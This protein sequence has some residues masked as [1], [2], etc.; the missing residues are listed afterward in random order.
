VPG[1]GRPPSDQAAQEQG[2]AAPSGTAAHETRP[3]GDAGLV[4][5]AFPA[6][7]A[8]PDGRDQSLVRR[9]RATRHHCVRH[10]IT[11]FPLLH[12]RRVMPSRARAVKALVAP[13]RR[14]SRGRARPPP[15][16]VAS[17][18]R[19][20]RA[21]HELFLSERLPRARSPTARQPSRTAEIRHSSR[22]QPCPISDRYLSDGCPI[23]RSPDRFL[24]LSDFPVTRP[25]FQRY[26]RRPPPTRPQFH[27]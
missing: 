18:T 20:V 15:A 17:A 26:G 1:N 25:I 6:A 13:I 11:S 7:S 12:L 3:G 14:V 19:K 27:A 4:G 22:D 8:D 5:K 10:W 21:R 24:A 2:A 9:T 23:F 16:A